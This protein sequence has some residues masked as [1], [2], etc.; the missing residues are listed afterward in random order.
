MS[1]GDNWQPGDLALCVRR[2]SFPDN[3]TR[4]GCLYTVAQVETYCG[5]PVLILQE[6][7]NEGA[8]WH[9]HWAD[10]FRK[11]AN[12]TDEEREEFLCGL[13]C[14]PAREREVTSC[15]AA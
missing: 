3:P 9:N 1:G 4:P 11:I 12:L 13:P 6:V 15:N 7:P 2:G 8:H 10:R 5:W 14:K